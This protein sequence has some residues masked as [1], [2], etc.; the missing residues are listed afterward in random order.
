MNREFLRIGT[1]FYKITRKPGIHGDENRI[2]IPWN[3]QTIID[4]HGKD[5]LANID[6]YDGFTVVPSHT[7]YQKVYGQF[8][9]KYHELSHSKKSFSNDKICY[10]FEFL[11][12]VFNEQIEIGLD[13]LSILWHYPTQILPILCLVSEER[14]TGKTT[15]LNWLKLL[16]QDNMTLNK[17]EDLRSRF[18]AD[19]TDKL[20]IA[21]DEVLLDR[22][23]DSERL[24]NLSTAQN[25]KTESK[26]KDKVESQFF[27]KFI[28]CSNNETNFILIDEKEIRYWVRK[29]PSI[30]NPTPDLLNHLKSELPY[31][32]DYLEKRVI[33][34]KRKSRMWF[35]K[36][37]IY[38]E[39]LKK[40]VQGTKLSL[41]KE[42][43]FLLED[44]MEEYETDT[45]DLS[46]NDLSELFS[47]TK[48][49]INRKEIRRIVQDKWKLSTTNS[50]YD[51]YYKCIDPTTNSWKVG[52]ENRR[53]RFY[54]FTKD[55]IK[56]V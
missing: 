21:V 53:G 51:L 4:D 47:K 26:G 52:K 32:I 12:H 33:S 25:Y 31:F 49:S 23:E 44:M 45:I 2:I 7:N 28:L 50:S 35:S 56:N 27:G 29:I 41:E 22:K 55:L 16:F 30:E 24:K 34:T 36:E 1:A 48:I 38:T 20:L 37:D 17:N 8:Y 18:N 42:L 43:I 11:E 6:K 39:S 19:W 54:R 14:S 9:N 40:L 46:Y 13:Y 3:R 15:F 10:S 5:E